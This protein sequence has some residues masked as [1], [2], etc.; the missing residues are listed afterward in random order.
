VGTIP[1]DVTLRKDHPAI[2]DG[3]CKNLTQGSDAMKDFPYV[4]NRELQEDASS[5]SLNDSDFV[6][7]SYK[8]VVDEVDM[9]LRL[10]SVTN[11]FSFGIRTTN[12]MMQ[13]YGLAS[14]P[15]PGIT[16]EAFALIRTGEADRREIRDYMTLLR[17]ELRSVTL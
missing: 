1:A 17:R 3:R 11:A 4:T 7:C 14:F 6:Q 8:I 13:R 2:A 10:I 16:L 9:K 15:V 5:T 12:A